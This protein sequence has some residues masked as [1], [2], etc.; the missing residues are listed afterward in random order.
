MITGSFVSQRLLD[1]D[2]IRRLANWENLASRGKTD[3]QFAS[4]SKKLFGQQNGERSANGATDN[5]ELIVLPLEIIKICVIT[6]PKGIT[7]C[8]AAI[9]QVTHNVPVRIQDADFR[10]GTR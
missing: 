7:S 9:Q 4:G 1:Q 2:K 10:D 3:Q 8:L 6:S 5:P